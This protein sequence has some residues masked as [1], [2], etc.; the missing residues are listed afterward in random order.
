MGVRLNAK[1]ALIPF[2]G[3][4]AQVAANQFRAT[5]KSPICWREKYAGRS[6]YHCLAKIEPVIGCFNLCHFLCHF[7]G[8]LEA[9]RQ[10]GEK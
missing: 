5:V 8:F 6:A 3:I 4:Q 10:I 1:A 9:P 7:D 2:I